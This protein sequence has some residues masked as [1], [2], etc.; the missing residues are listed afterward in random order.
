MRGD[1]PNLNLMGCVSRVLGQA[2]MC[3]GAVVALVW[4]VLFVL[5]VRHVGVFRGEG[6]PMALPIEPPIIGLSLGILGLGVAQ[7]GRQPSTGTA[8]V[9]LALNAVALALAVALLWGCFG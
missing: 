4:S 5:I 9:G 1:T 7:A 6:P 3:M 2:S 8:I